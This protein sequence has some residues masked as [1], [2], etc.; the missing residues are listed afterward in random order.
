MLAILISRA[1]ENDQFRG[2]VPHLVDG[3]LSILQCADDTLSFV[4]DDVE[5]AKNLKLVLCAFG[6]LFEKL[7]GRKRVSYFVLGK[8]RKE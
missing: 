2:Q 1:R 5:Q 3:G 4:E 6:K 7:F 8:Q